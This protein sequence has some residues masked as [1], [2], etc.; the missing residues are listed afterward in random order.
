MKFN[1]I[2][3]LFV[4][5]T[6]FSCDTD[7]SDY[8]FVMV[9]TPELMSKS[10]FRKSVAVSSAKD[11]QEAGKIYVYNDYIFVN[12]VQGIH[13]I[14][15]TNPRF[16]E[17]IKFITIPGNEDISV[18]DNYLFADSAT[19]L[20][21]FDI[22]NI[23]MIKEIE[24]L[25]DVFSVY[26]IQIP[27]EAE[28]TDYGKYNYE[29]DI[30]VGWTVKQERRKK[31][32]DNMMIDMVFDVA[33]LNNGTKAESSTG[34]GGS[35]A[36]FQIVDNYL[37]TVG[38]YEMA[39]FNI[40]NL[41]SP[42]LSNTQHAGWNIETMFEADDYL[43]LGSTNGMYIYSLN[44]P[45]S[46]EFVSEFTHWEGCDPVVVDGD[47]AYLTLRGGNLCGQ[48]ESVLEIIDIS[49]KSN[50][51]LAARHELENPYGLGIKEDVLFVCDGTAGLKLFDKSNPLDVKSIK[52]LKNIQSKDVIPLEDVLVMIGGETLYQYNYVNDGVELISTFSLK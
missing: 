32:D 4:F 37:Y 51:T 19:D 40:Q 17:K 12:D 41:A 9:A 30:I 33:A 10:E 26:D 48:L 16:P 27:I 11:I 29:E 50:P 47:F 5:A 31:M 36:R 7:D 25:E 35:L 24:R 21:V 46:P 44:N 20:L 52:T 1:Y 3:V 28:T 23:N 8:E 38:N 39:I 45:S 15:N 14:D 43:Y 2:I 6:I 13:I 22:S 18:K 49:D 42:T 34:I